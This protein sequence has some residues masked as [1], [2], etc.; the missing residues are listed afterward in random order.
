MKFPRRNQLISFLVLFALIIAVIVVINLVAMPL[1]VYIS[2]FFD[3]KMSQDMANDTFAGF[4][5]LSRV[6]LWMTLVII[7]VRFINSIIFDAGLGGNVTSG[8]LRNVLSITIY[9]IAF[10]IVFKS[11]FP[12]IDLAAVFTTSAILGVILGLALQDT[13]GNLFAGISLQADQPFQVGDVINIP[14]KGTGVIE[15]ITWRGLKIR[16]F[17]NKLLIVSNSSLGK[18]IIEVAPRNNLNANLVFFST[19][20]D[21]SPAQTI[22]V[23]REAIREAE[24]VSTKI[25]PIIRIRNLGDSGIEWEVKYWLNDYAKINDTDALIRQRIWYALRRAEIKFAFPTR[26]LIIERRLPPE[27]LSKDDAIFLRLNDLDVF[28]PLSDEE[29]M[30]LVTSSA[31]RVFAP[32]EIIIRANEKGDSMFVIHRGSVRIQIADN[33]TMRTV[34][35]LSEGE[36]FGEMAL[37]TGEPRTATVVAAEETEVLEIGHE[38]LK[39]LFDDNPYLVQDL[40]K[41]IA[42]RR[43]A[44]TQSEHQT[45][46]PEE[47]SAGIFSAIKRFFKL[48]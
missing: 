25:R 17:Q 5:K 4:V 2:G 20:Y 12:G 33:G 7:S 41:I 34:A 27:T 40:S 11:Q 37:F 35:K 10:F 21:E 26:T 44:L 23:V 22:Q 24:N 1:Q 29:T 19:T 48:N 43:I 14:T 32:G 3:N 47:Q 28:E 6:F 18:E 15:A 8:L 30:H 46:S 38:S 9:I 45:E 16:T 39:K 36:F 13:L 42:E 31:H